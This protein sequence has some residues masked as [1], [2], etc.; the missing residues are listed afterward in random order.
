MQKT[1]GEQ[2]GF[3][4][5]LPTDLLGERERE[6]KKRNS[7]GKKEETEKQNPKCKKA[8]YCMNK[9]SLCVFFVGGLY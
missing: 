1:M 8:K 5:N 2:L 6:N 4:I 7:E 9:M 3:I